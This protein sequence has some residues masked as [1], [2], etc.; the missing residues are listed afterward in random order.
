M[1]SNS[2]YLEFVRAYI[3]LL[4]R[5]KNSPPTLYIPTHN[6]EDTSATGDQNAMLCPGHPDDE[7]LIAA[8]ALRLKRE[9][10]FEI[11]DLAITL[12][13]RKEQRER[14]LRELRNACD[15]LG[16]KLILPNGNDGLENINPKAYRENS[17][18]WKLSVQVVSQ[19]ID[20]Y[21]PRFIFVS[22]EHDLH[23]THVGTHFLV[24]DALKRLDDIGH[25]FQCFL[26]ETEYW[27][28]ISAPNLQVELSEQ[29]VADLVTA[30]AFHKG[31]VERN[32]YHISFPAWLIDNGRRGTEIVGGIGSELSEISFA[33]LY[34]IM[35]WNGRELENA[36]DG[37]RRISCKDN[38][39][40]FL[41]TE[42]PELSMVEV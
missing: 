20:Q 34:H 36:Y 40:N 39:G 10:G 27:A 38:L 28:A 41:S 6:V 7:S 31:E 37:G 3:R 21:Q 35:R 19:I 5:W 24:L 17:P 1:S 42:I 26:V 18:E 22:H 4:E 33:T 23:P 12:G 32:P 9:L 11:I 16:F 15:Y 2:P 14:R 29:D 8:L 13:S 25:S 30:I